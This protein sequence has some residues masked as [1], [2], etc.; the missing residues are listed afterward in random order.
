[1]ASRSARW[2]GRKRCLKVGPRSWAER[3]DGADGTLKKGNA[4]VGQDT[5]ENRGQK[6]PGPG[7]G[8]RPPGPDAMLGVWVSWVEAMSGS[9]GWDWAS[10]AKP[11]WQM[12]TDQL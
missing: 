10:H 3:D 1:M 7:S 8:E 6:R 11:W 9:A 4:M 2:A 5:G 12:T